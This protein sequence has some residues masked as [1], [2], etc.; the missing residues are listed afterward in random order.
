MKFRLVLLILLCISLSLY[1]IPSVSGL[2]LDSFLARNVVGQGIGDESSLVW[3]KSSTDSG[4]LYVDRQGLE[5]TPITWAIGSVATSST[6]SS[7]LDYFTMLNN[8]SSATDIYIVGGDMVNGVPWTLADGASPGIDI[9]GLKAGL[10]GGAYNIIV[11][12]TAPYNK[13]IDNFPVGG[14]QSWGLEL[15]APTE[16]SDGLGKTCT[17]TMSVV[18]H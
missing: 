8:A 5:P 6:K 12:K 18:L 13:L 9:Y 16:F 4:E 10:D 1:F 17:V 11:R 3:V 2:G 15:Y 7:G 14:S